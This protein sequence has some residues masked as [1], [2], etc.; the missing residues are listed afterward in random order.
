[1]S[2]AAQVG[3]RSITA[4]ND[5]ISAAIVSRINADQHEVA[6]TAARR[7]APRASPSTAPSTFAPVS[8]S[9]RCSRRS[10]PSKPQNAPI[11]GAIATPT[12]SPPRDERD[13]N[14]RDQPD[15]D[16]AARRPIEEVR[17]VGRERDEDRVGEQ[18]PA[19]DERH[20][21]REHERD[22]GAA[23]DLDRPRRDPTVR[24]RTDVPAKTAVAF[25]AEQVV[26][27][28][29]QPEARDTRTARAARAMLRPGSSPRPNAPSVSR[30]ASTMSTATHHE[31]SRRGRQRGGRESCAAGGPG[32][33]ARRGPHMTSSRT[34]SRPTTIPRR[35]IIRGRLRNRRGG[36]D[37][38]ASSGGRAPRTADPVTPNG[39][40]DEYRRHDAE[41]D[42]RDGDTRVVRAASRARSHRRARRCR[43]ELGQALVQPAHAPRRAVDEI[44]DAGEHDREHD[45]PDASSSTPTLF[46]CILRWI[47]VDTLWNPPCPL[48]DAIS[49]PEV[50]PLAR[51]AGSSR[52]RRRSRAGP[53]CRAV[54]RDELPRGA[55][56]RATTS[57]SPRTRE[58][59]RA[60]RRRRNRRRARRRR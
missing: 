33:R 38:G 47:I 57:R 31:E 8:P 59:S 3:T 9:I 43:R 16:R 32:R 10:S 54:Q 17:E 30:P 45:R 52:S 4:L 11:T 13:R 22:R 27:Q 18:P 49:R 28:T 39:D 1:M 36:D 55:P 5:T 35:T 20:V 15:L 23:E 60:H 14:P 34:V 24:E 2:N 58:P 37:S 7:R 40:H 50:R 44:R 48:P 56:T 21:R 53:C 29:E 51:R 26:D 42:A 25:G 12:A 19:R 6:R 46:C 41:H